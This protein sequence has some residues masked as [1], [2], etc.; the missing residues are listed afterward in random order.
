MS[1]PVPLLFLFPAL[2]VGGAERQLQ[3]LVE[4]LDRRRFRPLVACQHGR[5]RIAEAL[6]ARGVRVRQ[7]SDRRRFD[8]GFFLRTLRL[9]RAEG[10]RLVLT[11]GFST[12]VVGRLAAVLAGA[13]VRILA[14]HATGERDMSANKHSVNRALAPLTSAWIAVA[15][16]QLEYL[17]RV[18]RIPLAKTHLIRN[19][20]DCAAFGNRDERERVRAE[21]GISAHARVAGI[22]AMLRPEKDHDT[23][24]HA[25]QRV[26]ERLD[27]ARFLIVGDGPRRDELERRVVE[28]GLERIVLFTG[29]RGD[30]ARVLSALDV[31][32]LCST[33][34]ET[35]PLA[36]LESMASALPL[37][38]TRVGGVPEVIEEGHNGILVQPRAPEELAAAMLRVLEDPETAQRWGRASRERA[39]REFGVQRMVRLHEKLFTALLEDAGVPVPPGIS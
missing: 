2:E 30:V 31:S 28:V 21:L 11:H 13:P 23:F 37:I 10:V 33:D 34:V 17:Q 5:G 29:W 24:L 8:A 6:E 32:V 7:L 39:E 3:L 20:I 15:D 27:E 36:L 14:E 26:V 22:V 16:G 19:G 25:A 4:R 12:G 18:K 38:G 1:E 35:M 9:V